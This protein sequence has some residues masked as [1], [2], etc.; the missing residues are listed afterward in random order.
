MVG[1]VYSTIPREFCY[2]LKLERIYIDTVTH[3]TNI[4]LPTQ[5][6]THKR[7]GRFNKMNVLFRLLKMPRC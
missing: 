4:W 7:T 5:V 3:I 1:G 6:L 2:S